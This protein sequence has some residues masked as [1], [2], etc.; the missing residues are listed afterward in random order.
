MLYPTELRAEIDVAA[1]SFFKRIA[2]LRGA[3]HPENEVSEKTN[4]YPSYVV[5]KS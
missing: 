2:A 1:N 3:L 4:L 5:T